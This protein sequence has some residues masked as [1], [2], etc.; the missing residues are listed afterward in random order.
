MHS[1]YRIFTSRHRLSPQP[2]TFLLASFLLFSSQSLLLL[3]LLLFFGTIDTH[4][5][6][7]NAYFRQVVAEQL[8]DFK[9]HQ[10][11]KN[12]YAM[13]QVVQHIVQ[14]VHDTGGRFMDQNWR[15][16]VRVC[17]CVLGVAFF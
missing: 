15:G 11:S 14:K 7:G 8:D 16:V 10:A 4:K 3:L 6:A 9:R 12:R 5:I 2:T 1:I 13:A 17:V